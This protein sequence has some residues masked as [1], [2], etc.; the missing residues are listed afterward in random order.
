LQSPSVDT[1]NAF[2]ETKQLSMQH[3]QQYTTVL[4]ELQWDMGQMGLT[5]HHGGILILPPLWGAIN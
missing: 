4:I 3:I 2:H 1:K 5:R